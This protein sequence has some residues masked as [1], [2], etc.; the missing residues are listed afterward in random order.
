MFPGFREVGDVQYGKRKLLEQKMGKILI[1]RNR[2][3]A[4]PRHRQERLR[5]TR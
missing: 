2:E 5:I 4:R 1:C 3:K